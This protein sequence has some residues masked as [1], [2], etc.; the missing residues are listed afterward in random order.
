[1]SAILYLIR[2]CETK[3]NRVKRFQGRIDTDI[4]EAG[5]ARPEHRGR[6]FAEVPLT[7]VRASPLLR[8]RTILFAARLTGGPPFSL[9]TEPQNRG[10][11]NS[12]A[13]PRF[14][15]TRGMRGT[16]PRI[17]YR[18]LEVHHDPS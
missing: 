6:R 4:S 5:A 12:A 17:Q 9:L 7:A 8:R 2:C 13:R 3:G 14:K 10:I 16:V 15:N 11:I 18:K 1:M